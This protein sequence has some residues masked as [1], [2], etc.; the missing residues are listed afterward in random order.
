MKTL[1]IIPAR[2]GSKRIPRKNVRSFHG[3]PI[4]AYPIQA[5]LESGCF[6]EVMVSTDDAEIAEIARECGAVVPF[7][8][9]AENA[10]DQAGSDD[11]FAEVLLR[12]RAAGRTHDC[13]CGIY[14]TA[15]LVTPERLRLG[16]DTLLADPSLTAV[17]PVQRFSFPIQRAVTLRG[18][19]LAMFQPEHFDTRSQ[20][21]EP[22]YHDAGQWY[23]LRTEPFLRTRELMGP[24]CAAIIL[25]ET[26]AQDIDNDTDWKLAEM[27]FQARQEAGFAS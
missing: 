17:L 7:L 18:G 16:R 14:P 4:I 15:A 5:A 20:D 1:C 21:L 27:K 6:D 2:G 19:R 10:T 13:A 26:E 12:Y 8:R 9:S 25:P 3:R 23:W 11:V 22:T 24:N